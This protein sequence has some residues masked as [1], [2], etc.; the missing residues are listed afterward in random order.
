M[1]NPDRK[2]GLKGMPF[3]DIHFHGL[4]GADDGAKTEEDMMSLVDAAYRDGVRVLCMTPHFHPGYYGDN[5]GKAERA[6]EILAQRCAKIYPDLILIRGNELH[7]SRDAL[8]WLD[9]GHCLTMNRT[10]NVL[11]D[12]SEGEERRRIIGALDSLLAAGYR[13]ILAHAERYR[14][15][16]VQDVEEMRRNGVRIQVNAGAL[17][18]QFGMRARSQAK[19]FLA[20]RLCDLISSDAHNLKY[21]PPGMAEAYQ[22]IVK[23]HGQ[24]YADRI[25]YH[26]AIEWLHVS[27]HGKDL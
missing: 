25:C 20:K 13:P 8:S 11:V 4:F 7:Y 10:H 2:E 14:N 18:R 24:E 6:F 5:R 22:Y 16:K 26:N 12:F 1:G 15:L 19:A 3:S 9:S 23:K 17:S 27:E 21:R